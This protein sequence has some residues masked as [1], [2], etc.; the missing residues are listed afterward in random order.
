MIKKITFA[1]ILLLINSCGYNSII[2]NSN[3]DF[4]IISIEVQ[5][6]NRPSYRIRNTLSNY[7][8]LSNK[9]KNFIIGIKSNIDNKVTS[10]DAK[11]DPKTLEL[12]ITVSLSVSENQ[13]K[14]DKKFTKS[15][16]YTSRANKFDLKNYENSIKDNLIDKIS[17][18]ITNYIIEIS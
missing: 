2:R 8:G 17:V 12:I 11:G 14:Y 3:T 6:Q 5:D 4:S 18:E 15:F 7:I 16:A 1:L 9:S 13:K 10:K